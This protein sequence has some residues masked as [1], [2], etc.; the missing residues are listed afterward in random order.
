[1]NKTYT[2]M[3]DIGSIAI[4][5]IGVRMFFGNGYGD[6]EF[7]CTISTKREDKPVTDDRGNIIDR[8]FIG[9]FEVGTGSDAWLL[10]YD[11]GGNRIHK[12]DNGRWFVYN[13]N[14]NVYVE[15]IDNYTD[16]IKG[17]ENV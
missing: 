8:K 11:C 14:G 10:D 2:V 16:L 1:M 15:Y 6:G 7:N 13:K 12:F 3:A 4:E 17:K 5:N 9:C